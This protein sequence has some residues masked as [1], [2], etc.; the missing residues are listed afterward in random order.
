MA[1]QLNYSSIIKEILLDYVQYKPAYGDISSS[2]SFDDEHGNYALLQVGWEGDEY[3]HGAIIHISLINN[4]IWIQYDG[5]E[6]G[7][8]SD[9]IDAGIPKEII[10]LGFKHPNIRQ[11]TGFALN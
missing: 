1:T 2:V 7:I 3:V 10:V 4:K 11:Y 9:L 6:E 5:T 8:A